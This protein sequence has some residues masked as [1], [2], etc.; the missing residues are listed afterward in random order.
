M[1]LF[2]NEHLSV[3]RLT[4]YE[5][6]ALAFFY[7]YV[8][9]GPEEPRGEAAAFGT[10]LHAVLESVYRWVVETEYEGAFPLEVLENN[11]R[12]AWLAA[13]LTG[14]ALYQEGLELLRTYAKSHATVSHWTILAVEREFNFEVGG[15][16]GSGFVVNGF[17]DRVDK[18]ADDWIA[19]VDYKSNRLLFYEDELE[20]NLQMSIYGLVAREFWPW[21]KRVSFVFHMLRHD[22][23]QGTERTAQQIDDAA[24]YIV[25]LGRRTEDAAQPWTPKLN[26]N[27]G[28]CDA[29]RRCETYQAAVAGKHEVARVRNLDDFAQVA[30]TRE[31]LHVLA[32]L[33]YA[34]KAELD[35][36]L[37]ARLAHEGEF[38]VNG[39]RYRTIDS[40]RLTY[41]NLDALSRAFAAAGVPESEVRARVLRVD[42]DAVEELRLEATER[43]D[44][45]GGL[46]LKATLEAV[47][48]RQPLSPKL[49][50]HK[51][52][53]APRALS[54][55]QP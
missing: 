50:S 54:E 10:V 30:Q 23:H 11:Y 5:Q 29:R 32:K 26:P 6:C 22:V 14:V 4:L 42:K 13:D 51:V 45:G 15:S 31:Q 24:G 53:V 18:L 25:S 39:Y 12:Y 21:A 48:E 2:R 27:C 37:K 16:A 7:R 43:L 55:K 34:R 40:S 19:I 46:L 36:L 8:D 1:N 28:Y 47:G 33:M 3:S 17:I 20:N 49:D 52:K 9:P 38:T 41:P 44:R 35:A